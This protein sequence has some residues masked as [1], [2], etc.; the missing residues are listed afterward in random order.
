MQIACANAESFALNKNK[1]KIKNKCLNE[2]ARARARKPLFK[3]FEMDEKDERIEAL[4][5]E[6]KELRARLEYTDRLLKKIVKEI[7]K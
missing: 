5:A 1:R 6:N 4:E 2:S 7:E 3:E